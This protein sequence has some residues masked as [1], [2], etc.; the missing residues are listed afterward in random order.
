MA[1]NLLDKAR[2]LGNNVKRVL[3]N[4]TKTPARSFVAPVVKAMASYIRKYLTTFF[5]GSLKLS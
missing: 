1:K 3:F 5:A 2:S 4:D